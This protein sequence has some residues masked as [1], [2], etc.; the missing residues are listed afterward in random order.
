MFNETI[1]FFKGKVVKMP[2]VDKEIRENEEACQRAVGTIQTYTVMRE[3][4]FPHTITVYINV[5]A[6][7]PKTALEKANEVP[8]KEVFEIAIDQADDRDCREAGRDLLLT[9]EDLKPKDVMV[10]KAVNKNYIID[11]FD[12][13]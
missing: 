5:Q 12:N 10:E 8:D 1:T 2:E 4:T 3:V 13:E 11:V 6:V 7:S 9:F